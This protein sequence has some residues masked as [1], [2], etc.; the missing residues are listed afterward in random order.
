[1]GSPLWLTRFCHAY[2]AKNGDECLADELVRPALGLKGSA[3]V[4]PAIRRAQI[5]ERTYAHL[6]E[7]E[8]SGQRVTLANLPN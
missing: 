8:R 4:P 3:E 5:D 1:L 6:S 2:L 7:S